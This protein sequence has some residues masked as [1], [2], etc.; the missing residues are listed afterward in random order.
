MKS[1]KTFAHRQSLSDR[2]EFL[3]VSEN[4]GLTVWA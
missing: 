2:D 4:G 3:T 1:E